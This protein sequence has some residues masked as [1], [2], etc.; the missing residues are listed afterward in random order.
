M[1]QSFDLDWNNAPLITALT[2]PW[3]HRRHPGIKHQVP[4]TLTST[5]PQTRGDDTFVSLN[6]CSEG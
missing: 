2:L 1:A 3:H 4:W 6:T 5:H